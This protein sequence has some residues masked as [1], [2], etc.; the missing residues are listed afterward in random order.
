[1]PGCGGQL[2]R[3]SHF[4]QMRPE[5]SHPRLTLAASRT[6]QGVANGSRKALAPGIKRECEGWTHSGHFDRSRPRDCRAARAR[7]TSHWETGKADE[8]LRPVSQET[9]RAQMGN[10]ARSTGI[11]P[12]EHV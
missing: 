6:Y 8:T 12:S 3:I 5:W 4:G 10:S 1:M 2:D 11:Y 9:C 7:P